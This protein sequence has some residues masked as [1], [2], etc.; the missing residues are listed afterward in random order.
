V[1]LLFFMEEKSYEDISDIL[2]IPVSTV[3]TLL[4]RAKKHFFALAQEPQFSY[5]FTYA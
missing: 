1:L 3:W 5:L 4:N 2:Q